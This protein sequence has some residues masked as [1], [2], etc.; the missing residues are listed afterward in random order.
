MSNNAKKETE[1]G[2]MASTAA[3]GIAGAGAGIGAVIVGAKAGTVGAAAVT[4]GLAAVGGTM[5]GGLVVVA[6]AP[7]AGAALGYG[8]YKWLKKDKSKKKR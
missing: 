8:V 7:V 5:L 6:A 1:A 3:G 4:S 2:K